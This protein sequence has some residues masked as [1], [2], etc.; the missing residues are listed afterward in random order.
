L[1]ADTN[2]IRNEI[3][4]SVNPYLTHI[5]CDY[6]VH[7]ENILKNIQNTQKNNEKKIKVTK[8]DY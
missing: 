6:L 2:K 4:R 8:I 1:E 5:G 7:K 3:Y